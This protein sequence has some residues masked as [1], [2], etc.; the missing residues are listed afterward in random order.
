MQVVQGSVPPGAYAEWAAGYDL[1]DLDAPDADA[2]G[3]GFANDEERIAGT[4]PTLAGDL[5]RATQAVFTA[6]GDG[7]ILGPAVPGRVYTARNTTNLLADWADWLT[8][9]LAITNGQI[10]AAIDPAMSNAVYRLIVELE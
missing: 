4:N 5:F 9:P 1:G 2:D 3:D 6:A 10:V 7:L 8:A